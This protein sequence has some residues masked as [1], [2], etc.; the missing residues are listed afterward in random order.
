MG[1]EDIMSE[2]M[3]TEEAASRLGLPVQT[4]R[5]FIQHGKFDEF[6]TAIKKE[7]ST[8]WTYYINR[9]RLEDYLK[10]HTVS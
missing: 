7:N 9:S 1:K 5:V 6:A 4:L 10:V 8:H 2:R 3:K